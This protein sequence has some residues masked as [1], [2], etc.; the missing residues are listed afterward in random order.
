MLIRSERLLLRAAE[1]ADAAFVTALFNADESVIAYGPHFPVSTRATLE[2]LRAPRSVSLIAQR[3]EDEAPVG[4]VRFWLS[5]G[6]TVM[7][8]DDVI[9]SAE[10]QGAGYGREALGALLEH[11]FRQW[12]GRRVELQVRSHNERAVR[13][14]KC[15]GFVEEGRRRQVVPPGWSADTDPDYLLMGLLADEYV[16]PE[17]RGGDSNE[18]HGH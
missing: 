17:P 15:L 4:F 14:Y 18:R 13:T 1:D 8:V 9:F 10:Y 2:K 5:W 11:F 16:P 12:G 6:D 7:N 3:L